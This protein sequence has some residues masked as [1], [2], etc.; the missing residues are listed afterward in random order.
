MHN[1]VIKADDFIS[2]LAGDTLIVKEYTHP[3][4]QSSGEVSV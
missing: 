3:R 1:E 2:I 4:G